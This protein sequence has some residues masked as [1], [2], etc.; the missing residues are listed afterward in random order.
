MHSALE[1]VRELVA[2]P[3][4]PG[5][6]EAVRAAVAAHAE[7][8]G[9]LCRADARGNLLIAPP[10]AAA[11]PEK[12]D[13]VV[14]AH[15][16]EIAL[17]TQ[18]VEDDG[19]LAVASLGG[20]LPW[21]W[22]E[23][24]V[25]ILAPGGPL[26]GILSFG[27]IHSTSKSNPATRA[28]E[29]PL[30]WE[31][32][33]IFTGLS[34]EELAAQ[35]VR[36]GTRIVLHPS[37]R[38]V[39]ELGDFLAAPF[40]DDRADLAALLLALDSLQSG[41]PGIGPN[42]L[43]AATAAEE[44]GGQGAL[45]LL[46]QHQPAVAI[47]LEIGPR[48]PESPFPLDAQPTVWVNDSYSAM[49][50]RDL[51]LVAA[52][53]GRRGP[54]AALA[55][56][57]ARR[58]RRLLRGVAWPG[59]PP[60]HHCI[61]CRKLPRLRNHAQGRRPQ[62]GPP[63]G[64][65]AGA[66]GAGATMTRNT[67]SSPGGDFF[68]GR[69]AR[70]F[71]AGCVVLLSVLP[72]FA[73]RLPPHYHLVRTLP[74]ASDLGWDYLTLDSASR[75]LY[76]TRSTHVDVFD[77]DSGLLVGQITQTN[78]VHGVAVAPALR[79]G[80]TSN[81]ADNSVTVFDLNTLAPINYIPVGTRPDCI[82]YDPATRRVFTFNGG[83][84][85]ATAIDAVTGRVLGTVPLGGSP[86]F[87]VADGRGDVFDNVEDTSEVVTLD[88]RTLRVTH[89]WPTAPVAGPSGIALDA[90]HRRVFSVGDNGQMAVLDADTGR[91]VATPAIGS[92]PDACAF[93]PATG[94]TFS[95]N[96]R[97]GTLTLVQEQSPQTYLRA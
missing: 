18:R 56:A 64:G 65:R 4:P 81:G 39:T 57:L 87:A 67:L 86:E 52:G 3:G 61:C 27:S 89:R 1:L 26:T 51:G 63:A 92:G 22:G 20:L 58:Q 46:Q 23:G 94:V 83:S 78:G 11:I 48:V 34:A 37:R 59:R 70:Q 96:G 2:L 15:L 49:Q 45:W 84:H 40:L 14:M 6:E 77:A 66:T 73:A 54:V 16:D 31:M 32:T 69:L 91:V 35:G 13:V 71:I 75:R 21:K 10:G 80:W 90:R 25:T 17:L 88:A 5:Q 9:C 62:P 68:R 47:A 12:T 29:E 95:S 53:G 82:V 79:R 36:P 19:R 60:H 97:D 7:A 76:V 85:D 24:P 30:T 44:V 42:V 93:D 74:L 28:R 43:F 55:G 38:T 8:R 50:A 33:R 72:A 41:S